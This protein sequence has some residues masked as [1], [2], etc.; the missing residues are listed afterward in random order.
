MELA[1]QKGEWEKRKLSLAHGAHPGGVAE[2]GSEN[3]ASGLVEESAS[4]ALRRRRRMRTRLRVSASC[5]WS[6]GGMLQACWANLEWWKVI[7]WLYS[8]GTNTWIASCST[9]AC[10][11]TLGESADRNRCS[12]ELGLACSYVYYRLGLE[13]SLVLL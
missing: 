5:L 9:A 12:S 7:C 10:S 11:V 2:L 3:R 13:H 8:I 4:T 1:L 6:L